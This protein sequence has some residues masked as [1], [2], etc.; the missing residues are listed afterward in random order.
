MTHRTL[1][2]IFRTR[3]TRQYKILQLCAYSWSVKGDKLFIVFMKNKRIEH[4]FSFKALFLSI[5][6]QNRKKNELKV[7]DVSLF[8]IFFC[9]T[10]LKFCLV[11]KVCLV[12]RMHM[13]NKQSV[14]CVKYINK[15]FSRVPG[16][17][18]LGLLTPIYTVLKE[19]NCPRPPLCSKWALFKRLWQYIE[20]WSCLS[21]LGP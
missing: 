3:Q 11:F 12:L 14:L 2:C 20:M 16:C 10:F 21:P 9:G 6:I 15:H 7:S 18:P 19:T 17:K 1:I 13:P 5:L 4:T 8:L